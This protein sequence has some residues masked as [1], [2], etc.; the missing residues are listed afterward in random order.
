MADQSGEALGASLYKIV[1]AAAHCGDMAESFLAANASLQ[2][3]QNG[4]DG[5]FGSRENRA[6]G[7]S[8]PVEGAWM[9]LRD[10]LQG[11]LG[12][13]YVN[14]KDAETAL[15]TIAADYAATDGG[16][17]AEMNRL[18]EDYNDAPDPDL[19]DIA[20]PRSDEKPD[21]PKPDIP[22]GYVEP[23]EDE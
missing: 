5:A 21:Y 23:S 20:P 6:G 19:G 22:D 1:E 12:Q 9:S 16:A 18:I 3:T 4:T 13:N 7:Q 10:Q 14:F 8:S 17:A 15:R 2:G 11:I